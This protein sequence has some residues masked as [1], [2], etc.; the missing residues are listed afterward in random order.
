MFAF[1]TD[2]EEEVV[3]NKIYKITLD[4]G[5]VISG[6]HLNGNNFVSYSPITEDVFDGNLSKVIIDDGEQEEIHGPMRLIQISRIG[7]EYLF[8]LDDVPEKELEQMKVRADLDYLAMM[9]EIEF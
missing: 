4:D 9:T 8:I 1:N 6:L 2:Y 7:Q 5:T 3:E